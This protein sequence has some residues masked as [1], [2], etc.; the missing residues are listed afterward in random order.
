MSSALPDATPRRETRTV[1]RDEGTAFTV[2]LSRATA[3]A[4]P[5]VLVV[6]AMG[7]PAGYYHRLIDALAEAGISAAVTEQRGYEA[8]GG[9]VPGWRYDFGYADLIDDL[10]ASLTALAGVADPGQG[11]Y[12][13]GHSLGGQVASGYLAETA[14]DPETSETSPVDGLLLVASQSPYWRGYGSR[15]LALSQAMGLLARVVGHFPGPQVGFAGREARGL[16]TEWAR[17]ARS[18]RLRYAGREPDLAAVTVPV[19][20]VTIDGDTLAPPDSTEQLLRLMPSAPVTRAHLTAGTHFTWA[21]RPDAVLPT[22][23]DWLAGV[24]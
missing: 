3:A 5:L 22:I 18:G 7:V 2:T 15:F 21:R 1:E 19:L 10:R 9:R 24:R 4:A 13:L 14:G 12:L 17:F 16:M 8:S 20:A 6:P 11:T 23:A